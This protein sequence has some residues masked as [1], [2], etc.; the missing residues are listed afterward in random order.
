MPIIQKSKLERRS[1]M[2]KEAGKTRLDEAKPKEEG[3][4]R[5]QDN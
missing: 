1:K 4:L 3:I 5:C 2:K